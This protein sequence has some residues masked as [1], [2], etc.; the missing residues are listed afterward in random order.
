MYQYL[1]VDLGTNTHL[2]LFLKLR[3]IL[4]RFP[5]YKMHIK[6]GV[7]FSRVSEETAETLLAKLKESQLSISPTP[8]PPTPC[9]SRGYLCQ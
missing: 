2:V 4:A 7:P 9:L 8:K 1:R 5:I 3:R 6:T